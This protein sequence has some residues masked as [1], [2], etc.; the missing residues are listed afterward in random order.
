MLHI[1]NI[2]QSATVISILD[3]TVPPGENNNDKSYIRSRDK[4][5]VHYRFSNRPAFIKLNDRF[6]FREG[7]VRGV[8]IISKLL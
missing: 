1:H 3:K 5:K 7:N 2:R 4:A 8:G 6:I